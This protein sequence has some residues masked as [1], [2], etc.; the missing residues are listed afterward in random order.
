VAFSGDWSMDFMDAILDRAGDSWLSTAPIPEPCRDKIDTILDILHYIGNIEIRA[1]K[2]DLFWKRASMAVDFSFPART[3][4]VQP[5]F[6]AILPQ[7][8]SSEELFQFSLTGSITNL[9]RVY[10]GLINRET[11][12]ESLSRGVSGTEIISY[13]EKWE[14]PVNVVET[15]REW[16]REFSRVCI[17]SNDIIVTG[18][19]KSTMEVSSFELL[20]DIVEPLTAHQVFK[21][22]KGRED[23]ARERLVT[24]GFDPRMPVKAV[25]QELSTETLLQNEPVTELTLSKDFKT[26]SPDRAR[27]MTSGKYSD[28]L[29]ALDQSEMSHVIDYAL[30]MGHRLI[31]DYEGS[32]TVKAGIYTIAPQKIINGAESRIKGR[33]S[34]AGDIKEFSIKKISRI[35]VQSG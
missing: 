13:M 22:K 15:V 26:S 5:D 25:P 12:N 30:L 28:E 14:A 32:D 9:D 18:D 4:M 33:D 10:N 29:K 3:V 7:E 6:S 27:P 1:K 23:E 34:V 11:V 19:K 31:L 20:R 24:M 8:V 2:G 21:I 35:G 16:I 17:I